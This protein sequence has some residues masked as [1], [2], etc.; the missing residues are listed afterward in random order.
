MPLNAEQISTW[1]TV[2]DGRVCP[3]CEALAGKTMSIGDWIE[4]GIL[5]GNGQTICQDHCRC[6]IVPEEWSADFGESKTVDI[7][8][9]KIGALLA[10]AIPEKV[11]LRW[12]VLME[13]NE[14]G[15]SDNPAEDLVQAMELYNLS[16]KEL[17]ANFPLRY[18]MIKR[19]LGI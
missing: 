13:G 1:V 2:Q 8:L 10:S 6:I 3:D 5:P 17:D 4:S 16:P 12:E 14:I 15:F 18:K 19:I 11:G 9:E 7:A